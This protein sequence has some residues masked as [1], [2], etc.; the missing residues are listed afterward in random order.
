MDYHEQKNVHDLCNAMT[1]ILQLPE[2]A[3]FTFV[4]RCLE[5]PQK[6]LLVS[7]KSLDLSYSPGFMN[8]LFLRTIE[9]GVSNP[10]LVQEIKPLLLSDN[11]C[12]EALLAAIF[13]TSPSEKERSMLQA[14]QTPKKMVRFHETNTKPEEA[15]SKQHGDSISNP[16]SPG[17][18]FTSR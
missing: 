6:I 14:G 7:K 10:F 11:V 2:K 17:K 1:N 3:V 13:K 16:V 18:V 15:K 5:V 12:D 4:M 8:K 9:R